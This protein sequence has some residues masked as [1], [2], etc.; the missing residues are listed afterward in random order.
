MAYRIPLSYNPIDVD[1][2]AKV[3]SSYEGVHHNQMVTDFEN[4]IANLTSMPHAVAVNSGTAAIHLALLSLGIGAGD[5]VIA[6]TFTYVATINP[7]LYV[8]AQPVLI[9]VE[10][11]TWNMDPD[12]LAASIKSLKQKGIKPKAIII[13]HT[14]GMPASVNEILNL[15]KAEGIPIIEDAAESLGAKYDGK[16][17]GT[18]GDVG[19]YSFNNNKAITTFGGGILITRNPE[20]AEKARYYASQARENLPFYEHINVGYNYLISPLNA[21]MGLSQ[22]QQLGDKNK[23]RCN[24][25]KE[26]ADVLKG[27]ADFQK[28][29]EKQISSRWLSTFLVKDSSTKELII[30]QFNTNGIETRPLWK[31]MHVQPLYVNCEAFVKGVSEDYFKRGFALPSS[32]H[33]LQHQQEVIHVLTNSLKMVT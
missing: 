33:S 14:Y 19:I 28:D 4:A 3:L 7:I 8:G 31:P 15:A 1:S 25:F 13:V 11:E 32:F 5:V 2:F 6:P 12:L 10:R 24:V 23:S 27:S 29:S 16:L 18:I 30:N 21:A 20:T 9:D 26:Y 17:T 22:I